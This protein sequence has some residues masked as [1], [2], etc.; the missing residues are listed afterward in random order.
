MN[1]SV[2]LAALAREIGEL[3]PRIGKEYEDQQDAFRQQHLAEVRLLNSLVSMVKPGLP[4]ICAHLPGLT[5]SIPVTF[6]KGILLHEGKDGNN[7][8]VR[9]CLLEDGTFFQNGMRFQDDL[10]EWVEY[11]VKRDIEKVVQKY[12]VAPMIATIH[13]LLVKQAGKRRLST[14]EARGTAATFNAILTLLDA[15]N[16]PAVEQPADA[17]DGSD[18][19]F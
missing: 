3:A 12:D 11:G 4:A 7:N 6:D 15:A 2:K 18:I 14:V 19:P 8:T 16:V 10:G 9:L 13:G 1:D 17:E 5:D